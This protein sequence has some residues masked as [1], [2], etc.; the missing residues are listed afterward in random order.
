M[1]QAQKVDVV[2]IE[3][4]DELGI[5]EAGA[6]VLEAIHSIYSTDRIGNKL[7]IKVS[8]FIV[9]MVTYHLLILEIL[10]KES[11]MMG[12]TKKVFI[13]DYQIQLKHSI[14]LGLQRVM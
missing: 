7:L 3:L 6:R 14:Q 10:Y 13:A 1:E 5:N 2:E 8:L 9:Y 11:S 12:V 4:P